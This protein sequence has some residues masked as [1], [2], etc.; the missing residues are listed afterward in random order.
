MLITAELELQAATSGKG[1]RRR[2]ARQDLS[3]VFGVEFVEPSE[4]KSKKISVAK[5]W[6]K[7]E[8][9]QRRRKR[10]LSKPGKKQRGRAGRRR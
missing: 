3:D 7:R 6:R 2:L 10:T 8:S 1:N 4:A 5:K 9:L